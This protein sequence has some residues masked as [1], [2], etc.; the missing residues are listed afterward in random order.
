MIMMD[1]ASKL[2]G[3]F[4]FILLLIRI[5]PKIGGQWRYL[6]FLQRLCG[7]SSLSFLTAARS[8][9]A[10]LSHPWP[11]GPRLD[12]WSVFSSRPYMTLSPTPAFSQHANQM[13]HVSRPGHMLSSV[14]VQ[15]SAVSCTSLSQSW[16]SCSSLLEL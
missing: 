11:L 9:Q 13:F 5:V 3:D 8:L 7:H 6:F 4:G 12:E 10:S 14:Q 2:L 16:S 1:F 15:R